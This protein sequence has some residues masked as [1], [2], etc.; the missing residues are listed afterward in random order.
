MLLMI[1]VLVPSYNNG[2]SAAVLVLT[3]KEKLYPLWENNFRMGCAFHYGKY[4][5]SQYGHTL[6]RIYFSLV[7]ILISELFTSIFSKK[8]HSKVDLP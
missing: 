2:I 3:N 7:C 6:R 8:L 5:I 1:L 4:N